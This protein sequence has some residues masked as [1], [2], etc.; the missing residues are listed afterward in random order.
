MN[1][2]SSILYNYMQCPHRVWRDLHG[3]LE[4]RSVEENPFVELLWQKGVLHE[5]RVVASLGEY[6]DLRPGGM[7][8]RLNRTT[9]HMRAGTPLIY[10]G[11]LQHG[12]LLGIPDLLRLSGGG[13][14]TPMDIKSGLGLEGIDEDIGG[15]RLKSHYAVQLCL[16]LEILEKSGFSAGNSGIILDIRGNEVVYDLDRPRGP[17]TPAP[18]TALYEQIKEE[19]KLLIND[20][21]RNT[22]AL[23]GVCKL[24]RWYRSCRDWCEA[25]DDLSMIFCL[26]RGKR[27]AL[28]HDLGVKKV[29]N[30]QGVDFESVMDR[31]KTDR[32]FLRGMGEK[33]LRRIAARAEILSKNKPPLVYEKIEFPNVETELFFDI[34]DDPTQDFIYLHGLYR[35]EASR[36]NFVYFFAVECS[37]EQER[38][39]WAEFWDFMDKYDLSRT[40]VYFYS[41]H[42]KTVYRKLREKY[43][44][45]ISEDK[46]ESFFEHENV[47]DLYGIVYKNTDWPLSS[48]SVKDIANYL[49]FNWRDKSPSGVLSI[50]WFNEYL[51]TQDP[52]IFQRIIEYNEDDCRATMV[53]KDGLKKLSD[54]GFGA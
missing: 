30:F 31:K 14:Y 19:V 43:P 11:V 3:P 51:K 1:L 26:G 53:L 21:A 37:P 48:Y 46:L 29:G 45:V 33:T 5:E 25:A 8:E 17:R 6:A 12:E 20:S 38:N 18:W 44:D 49:G 39:A 40:A 27:D 35:R 10:Q 2:T 15:G 41:A 54:A 42:E 24:C 4:E 28:N 50:Q 13:C 47:I 9:E 22:P 32:G 7:D 16:Y 23:S 52:G 36:E 34:E